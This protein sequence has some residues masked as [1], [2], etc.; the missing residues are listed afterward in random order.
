MIN[1]L[2]LLAV[3]LLCLGAV[4]G[5]ALVSAEGNPLASPTPQSL[6]RI[7]A[8]KISGVDPEVVMSEGIQGDTHPSDIFSPQ[9]LLV[10]IFLPRL[11][12]YK[13]LLFFRN[14][15]G[16]FGFV[17][18]KLILIAL[19]ISMLPWMRFFTVQSR[20][21]MTSRKLDSAWGE[22][23]LLKNLRRKLA[24]LGKNRIHDNPS[25]FDNSEK[26]T[27]PI[28]HS[29]TK[30]I[31]RG[32]KTVEYEIPVYQTRKIQVGFRGIKRELPVYEIQQIQVGYKKVTN[33]LNTVS[34]LVIEQVPRYEKRQFQVGTST[35]YKTVPVF[36]E[37]KIQIGTKIVIRQMP[38]YQ[39]V[40]VPIEIDETP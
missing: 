14:L 26:E 2:G 35:I 17:N 16:N 5:P 18:Q 11:I 23:H 19:I 28:K 30:T 13:P 31:F 27:V 10:S 7:T 4:I 3:T 21:F 40:N 6:G 24:D 8:P 9:D 36:E 1:K 33:Q 37:F 22:K 38:E 34:G 25:R 39:M 12:T 29:E 15:K 20:D 32:M